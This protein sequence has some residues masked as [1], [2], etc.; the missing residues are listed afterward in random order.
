M[1]SINNINVFYQQKHV[2][3]NI[4]LNLNKNEF[5][6]ILGPN[7]AGKSTLLKSINGILKASSGDIIINEKDITR[8][9]EKELARKIAFIPQ[10]LVMQFD[11]TVYEFVLMAR[12]PYLNYFG[13]YQENDH[14]VVQK[15]LNLLKIYDFKDR[16]FNQLSGGEKQKVLITRALVQETE[17]ILMD[18]SLCFLD[19][20]HQIEALEFLKSIANTK[21]IIIVSHNLN[22]AAEFADRIVFLKEG[23]LVE[24]GKV[25]DVF[26]EKNLSNIFEMSINMITNPF[27]NIQNIVYKPVAAISDRH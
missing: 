7:G 4:A 14:L 12:F 2:L 26:T 20:N 19:I 8:Y 1:I 21:S 5:T 3:K 18:E 9:T 13:H 23:C 27:T 17:Y 25:C 24:H 6:F 10:E 11:Y 22:L 15:Y 16:Y